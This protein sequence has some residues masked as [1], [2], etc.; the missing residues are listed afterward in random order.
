MSSPR[1]SIVVPALE[2]QELLA[3]CL[4]PLLAE[5]QH[6]GM[7]DE[8]YV[9]DDTGRDVLSAWAKDHFPGTRVIVREKNGGFGPALLSGARIGTCDYLFAMNPDVIV[10][11]GFLGPLVAALADG[12]VD[13]VSPRILLGGDDA[14]PESSCAL[15]I[16]DGRLRVVERRPEDHPRSV[17]FAVGGAFLT[18]RIP[19]LEAGG[20]DPLCAPFYFEDVD[21]GLSAWRRGQRILEVPASVVEHHHRGSIGPRVPAELVQAAVEKNRLL[22]HWKHLDNR[23]DA[24]EHL[25]ALWR[26][27]LDAG[28]GDRR[29]EL[30]WMA[31]AIAEMDRVAESRV[32]VSRTTRSLQEALRVSDPSG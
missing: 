10:R 15:T 2:D 22:V 25:S 28:L 26:D 31:L 16:Q 27:A 20:F 29:E 32:R 17:P 23:V 14:R 6:R 12:G 7:D 21:F 1:V 11:P 9:V 13:A 30:I 5:M 4:P 19:F 18:R 3:E 24:H 8:L